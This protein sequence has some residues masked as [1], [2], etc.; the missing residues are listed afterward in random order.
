M[1]HKKYVSSKVDR[2][3]SLHKE[4]M[5]KLAIAELLENHA[6][7]IEAAFLLADKETNKKL[8]VEQLRLMSEKEYS[9]N[10]RK[11]RQ[12]SS[13]KLKKERD[14][15]KIVN[16]HS[17]ERWILNLARN[18]AKEKKEH[19]NVEK[20]LQKTLDNKEEEIKDQCRKN[21]ER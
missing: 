5:H 19:Q 7:E 16:D 21:K 10:L 17:H 18:L 8:Q 15:Q 1:E 4:E 3:A 9:T 12:W 20:K 6:L 13:N 2:A 14:G 11:E